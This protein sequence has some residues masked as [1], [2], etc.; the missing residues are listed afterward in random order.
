MYWQ[1]ML[2]NMH[3]MQLSCGDRQGNGDLM[4][5]YSSWHIKPFGL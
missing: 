5:T 3:F 2:T 4:D 1:N